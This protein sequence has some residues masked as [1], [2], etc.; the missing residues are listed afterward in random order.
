M[1]FGQDTDEFLLSID[2]TI[3]LVV[4][5][6]VFGGDFVIHHRVADTQREEGRMSGVAFYSTY[7]YRM[8]RDF[9]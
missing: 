6:A 4:A 2:T 7:F 8:K 1:K 3:V 9:P 5:I